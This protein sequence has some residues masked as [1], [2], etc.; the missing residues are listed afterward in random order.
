MPRRYHQQKRLPGEGVELDA[1]CVLIAVGVRQVDFSGA[2]SIDM[3]GN[4]KFPN[5]QVQ[6]GENTLHTGR[7]AREAVKG[8]AGLERHREELWASIGAVGRADRALRLLQGLLSM[9]EEFLAGW[10]EFHHRARTRQ[11]GCAYQTFQLPNLAAQERLG[12]VE[13]GSCASKMQLSG[14]SHEIAHM[15]QFDSVR[16]VDQL[17]VYACGAL[18]GRRQLLYSW[19]MNLEEA[20]A[21]VRQHFEDFV[22]R[23]DLTAADRNFAPDYQEHGSDSPAGLPPGPEGPKQYLA[24]AFKRFPDIHVT[25]EDIIAEGDR[26]VVRNTWLA[27]DTTTSQRIEFSGIVIWR[28]RDGKLAE[29]WAY[30][31]APHPVH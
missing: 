20:K 27:T 26:V 21:F 30:L 15:A 3:L 28:L 13:R 7:E 25:I 2:Q 18:D 22:N 29:R 12:Y 5:A 24:T 31:Q 10:C 9:L 17:S 11:Q 14:E 8:G 16:H 23:K 1:G 4:R 6:V 19:T